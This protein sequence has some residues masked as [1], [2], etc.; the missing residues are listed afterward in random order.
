MIPAWSTSAVPFVIEPLGQLEHEVP[1]S[2]YAFG[3]HTVQF[4]STLEPAADW[5]PAGQSIK[6]GAEV[7]VPTGPPPA[8]YLFAGQVSGELLSGVPGM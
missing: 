8:Q 6:P 2:L 7:L 1:A 5:V 4:A 3:A